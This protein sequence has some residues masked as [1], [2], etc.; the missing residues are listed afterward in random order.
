MEGMLLTSVNCSFADLEGKTW[1]VE[2]APKPSSPQSKPVKES[3]DKELF[4]F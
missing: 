2:D 4:S 3:L 1:N